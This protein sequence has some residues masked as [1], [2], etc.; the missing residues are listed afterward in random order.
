MQPTV[1]AVINLESLR[2]I[3]LMNHLRLP[4]VR[5]FMVSAQIGFLAYAGSAA[6]TANAD[7]APTWTLNGAVSMSQS[8][9]TAPQYTGSA[10]VTA[11]RNGGTHGAL[12]VSYIYYVS[13]AV[14]GQQVAPGNGTLTWADGDASTKTITIPVSTATAFTGTEKLAVRLTAGPSTLL[15]AHTSATV[16]VVGGL[17]PPLVKKSISAWVTCDPKIDESTQLEVAIAA[18]SNNAFDL[19]IDCPVRFH[20][21][22]AW[23]SSIPVPDGVTIS[24]SGAGEFLIV[25]GGPPALAVA[26]PALVSFFDWN[27]TAL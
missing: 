16:D 4:A 8:I 7:T 26:H 13:A 24:F 22:T 1:A 10:T 27:I 20:T 18:A 6:I 14:A 25:D 5:A 15:G 23:N 21:G 9:F 12:S 2:G 11:V 3:V 19:V 17:K